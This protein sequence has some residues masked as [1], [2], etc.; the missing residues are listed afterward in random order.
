[1]LLVSQSHTARSDIFQLRIWNKAHRREISALS[2]VRP[3]IPEQSHVAALLLAHRE[4][5]MRR[6]RHFSYFLRQNPRKKNLERC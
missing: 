4:N 2:V 5:I 3:H 6:M 1:M